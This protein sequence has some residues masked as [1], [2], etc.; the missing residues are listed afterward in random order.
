MM[1]RWLCTVTIF[2]LLFNGGCCC[3]RSC[4]PCGRPACCFSLPLLR[5]LHPITWDGC[6]NDCG[7]S[8]CESCAGNCGPYSDGLLGHCALFRG[9]LRGCLSC[10]RGCGEI[11]CD[12]WKS[13]PPDCCDPCDQCY[14]QFTGPHGYCNLGPCQRILAWLDGY[15]YCPPP[16]CGPWRPIFGHC[17]ARLGAACGNPG[18]ST[19]G[20]GAPY[21]GAPYG[22]MPSDGEVYYDGAG[23]TQGAPMNAPRGTP[24]RN[25]SPGGPAPAPRAQPEPRRESAGIFED[26]GWDASRSQPRPQPARPLPTAQPAPR[27]QTS[28]ISGRMTPAQIAAARQAA[29]QR[30]Y[31]AAGIR[32]TNYQP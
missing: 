13:D 8:P 19:C 26:D 1:A 20:G 22:G 21:G 32:S 28:G 11:Y 5:C 6:C 18:C 3:F 29:R 14:G 9:C 30:A 23:M 12:E 27:F 25:L 4:D 31:E 10:G 16:N 2:T 7:P 24:S 15:R 17:N